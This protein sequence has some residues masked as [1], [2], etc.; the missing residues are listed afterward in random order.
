MYHARAANLV[1]LV[2][3]ASTHR[4]VESIIAETLTSD[5]MDREALYHA[6]G[7]LWRLTGSLF[8][9]QY[10]RYSHLTYC[11][12]DSN[13]PGFSLKVPLMIILD[14]LKNDDPG[15]RRV[16]ETWMRCSLR[17]Y[18]RYRTSFVP[19][20]SSDL[21]YCSSVLDPILYDLLDPSMKRIS[22]V[23]KI[24]GKELQGFSYER[25][26]DQTYVNH[27]LETLLSVVKFGGQ[28]FGKTA[29]MNLVR[30]S[31]S[32]GL[33]DRILSGELHCFFTQLVR[34]LTCAYSSRIDRSQCYLP[35]RSFRGAHSVRG[36]L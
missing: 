14:A 20:P 13:L 30:R 36:R 24:N 11:I 29:R 25:S 15:L 34:R 1:W 17:S 12:E 2:E 6:F 7:T 23:T 33:V 32:S 28:G 3:K 22:S 18:L 26:F 4:Q 10:A 19:L 9:C 8:P 31:H 21:S 35:G 16:G 5:V 27:L